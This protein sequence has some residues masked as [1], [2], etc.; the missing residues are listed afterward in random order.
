MLRRQIV[1]KKQI[2]LSTLLPFE[3]STEKAS[4]KG[5]I[6][7]YEGENSVEMT[8]SHHHTLKKVST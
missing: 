7:V 8:K 1:L 3:M 4:K 5:K 2:C 6:F